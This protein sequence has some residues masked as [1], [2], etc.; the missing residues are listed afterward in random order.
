MKYDVEYAYSE[1][2]IGV[3]K[4]FPAPDGA[5]NEDIEELVV[6]EVEMMYPE[7]MDICV[8]K[9]TEVE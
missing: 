2:V 4:D 3:I 9:I 7:A 8:I 5:T 6:N 1:P